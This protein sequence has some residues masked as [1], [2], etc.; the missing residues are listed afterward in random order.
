MTILD[1]DDQ[2]AANAEAA[3]A[4]LDSLTIGTQAP[5][6]LTPGGRAS[7][8]ALAAAYVRTAD[9]GHRL[10]SSPLPSVLA[11]A[12]PE[13]FGTR[14]ED[15]EQWYTP[16]APRIAGI[17]QVAAAVG[18]DELCYLLYA[19]VEP[20]TS[21]LHDLETLGAMTPYALTAARRRGDGAALARTLLVA[22]GW[23]KMSGRL[24]EAISCCSEAVSIYA[25]LGADD[26]AGALNRRGAALLAAHRLD[27]AEDD[28]QNVIVLADGRDPVMTGLAHMNLCILRVR[29]GEW[30]LAIQAGLEA[31]RALT[32][33][34]ADP[35]YRLEVAVQLIE[36]FVGSGELERAEEYAA[37]ARVLMAD[38]RM[39]TISIAALI[40]I[41]QLR[42]AQDRHDEALAEFGQAMLLQAGGSPWRL[43]DIG[44]GMA[45]AHL[46]LA[47]TEQAITVLQRVLTA[48]R[49]AGVGFVTARTLAVL[50]D[51]L[52][53]AER[54]DE[55]RECRSQALALLSGMQDAAAHALRTTLTDG[56]H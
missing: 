54:G 35:V 17:V 10:S 48:R 44:E 26:L 1:L 19:A 8:A 9:A 50:A 39:A 20:M 49:K 36:A 56:E 51:A 6:V 28:F 43:A 42:L 37:N 12:P 34:K 45:R 22:G 5:T 21:S 38:T 53:A 24:Q 14:Y 32:G 11:P 2:A 7:L 27:G 52:V 18:L 4:I 29:R 3:D 16:R 40:T 31:D 13:V 23:H 15:A 33:T 25:E 55:A 30:A 46:A 47:D 41:G